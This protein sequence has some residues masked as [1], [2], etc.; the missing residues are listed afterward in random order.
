MK[1][2][3]LTDDYCWNE[4]GVKRSLFD[5]LSRRV[6]TDLRFFDEHHPE[7][8]FGP[9][10]RRMGD[11]PLFELAASGDYT[12]VF[13]ASSGLS[14]ELPLMA[15]LAAR[16]VRVGFGFSDPRFTEFAK[17]H[18]SAFDC[19]FTLSRAMLQE[20]VDLGVDTHVMLPSV[21]PGFHDR[22]HVAP[23]RAEYDLVFMGDLQWHPDAPSRRQAIQ[24][25][26]AAGYAVCTIGPGGTRG[27]LGGEDLIRALAS[28]RIG[29]NFMDASSTIPHRLFE[30]AAVGLCVVTTMTTE[31]GTAFRDGEEVVAYE[32]RTL[33]ALLRDHERTAAIG[34]R[35]YRRC[36]VEHTIVQRVDDIMRAVEACPPGRAAI[37]AAP[38]PACA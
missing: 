14:F 26:E 9:A 32:P 7:A 17:G 1:I 16:A 20:A 10:M 25:I 23:D 15:H 29:L 12:H 19:Y 3:Y 33:A 21:H 4:Y 38:V 37:P 31:I 30:Y 5:E 2:L 22:F 13:F 34:E 28:G 11:G 24:E 27:R 36:M 18:W 6:P 35:G 8:R